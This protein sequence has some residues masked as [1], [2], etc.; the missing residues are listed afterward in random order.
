MPPLLGTLLVWR[1]GEA[2]TAQRTFCLDEDLFLGDHTLGRHISMFDPALRGLPIMPLTVSMEMLAEA[3]SLLMPDLVLVEMND[4]RTYRWIALEDETMTLEIEARRTGPDTVY[5]QIREANVKAPP[6]VEANLRFAEERPQPPKVQTFV[7]AEERASRWQPEAIYRSG[8]FHGPVFQGVTSMDRVGADGATATLAVTPRAAFLRDEPYPSMVTDPVLLDQPGQ[9]VGLWTAEMLAEGY[10]IF[11]YYLR[12]LQLF[13]AAPAAHATCHARI[14][15]VGAGGVRSDLDVVGDD[16]AVWLRMLAWEDRRFDLPRPLFELIHTQADRF[17]SH[18]GPVATANLPD[19]CEMRQIRL[20][21]FGEDFFTSHGGIW[22]KM[23]AHLILG[24]RERQLWKELR[25]PI[26]RRLEWLL[27]RLAGKDAVRSLLRRRYGL[28]LPLAD[29]EIL[30]DSAGRPM[31]NG[32]WLAQL[33]QA[34]VLSLAHSSGVAVALVAD[35]EHYQGAGIDLEPLGRLSEA[36]A[37]LS[38]TTVEQH[39]LAMLPAEWAT[40]FWCAKEA[41]GKAL[42]TGLDA[43]PAA[44]EVTITDESS[45]AVNVRQVAERAAGAG[46]RGSLSGLTFRHGDWITAVILVP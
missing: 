41:A 17:L 12:S 9:V 43:G 40:R 27:G 36:V 19:G 2:V 7:L 23:L 24:R 26:P 14:E 6:I 44:M 45:G 39:L 34:P 5:A 29:V 31:V 15:L 1:P 46:A 18:P 22:E 28:V 37:G 3:G 35:G 16:G 42:G 33:P 30:P 21:D 25:L 10:V 13:A 11:P 38:F 4:V 20:A 8:M 32:D